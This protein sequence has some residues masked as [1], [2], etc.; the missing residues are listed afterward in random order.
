MIVI[1]LGYRVI[2]CGLFS[3]YS[4]WRKQVMYTKKMKQRGLD[5]MA[6]KL[7]KGE[8]SCTTYYNTSWAYLLR[9]VFGVEGF[10]CP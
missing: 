6:D 4:R 9:R 8:G 3:E 5:K 7:S 1:S 10:G 2:H